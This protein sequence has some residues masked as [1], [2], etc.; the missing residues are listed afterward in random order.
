MKLLFVKGKKWISGK[1]IKSGKGHFW[2][3]NKI[4]VCEIARVNTASVMHFL[5]HTQQKK[6][7]LWAVHQFGH[8]CLGSEFA[9]VFPPT[10]WKCQCPDSRWWTGTLVAMMGGKAVRMQDTILWQV[11]RTVR[12]T[13]ICS[14]LERWLQS[15][16]WLVRST[17]PAAPDPQRL[18]VALSAIQPG[19]T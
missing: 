11:G 2:E 12:E 10:E 18:A 14:C 7:K 15:Y 19:A 9:S 13:R 5:N 6:K 17:S 4:Q 3:Q 1:A 8:R 16:Q